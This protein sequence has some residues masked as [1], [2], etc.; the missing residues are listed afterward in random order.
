MAALRYFALKRL[1]LYNEGEPLEVEPGEFIP[2]PLVEEW[3]DHGVAIAVE[4]HK[5]AAAPALDELAAAL[6]PHM[7]ELLA[8]KARRT[9]AVA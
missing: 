5:I 3:G 9:A 4:A 7:Q 1:S 6:L 2:E 8:K